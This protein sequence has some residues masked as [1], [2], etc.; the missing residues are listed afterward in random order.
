MLQLRTIINN[1][2]RYVD[3]FNDED[4]QL[5]YSFAEIQDIT[6]KNSSF[7]KSFSIP[8]S[9]NNNDIFQHYY[10]LNSSLTDYDIRTI[11][12]AS[13]LNDGY[14]IMK[15][16]IRLE[17]V[18]IDVKNVVYKVVFYSEVGRLTS[19]M[20]DKVL[21]QVD[22]TELD[23][24][25]D[26]EVITDSIYDPDFVDTDTYTQPYQD[27]RIT[28]MLA[29]Y[30]YDYDDSNNIITSSTPIIDYRDGLTSGY[31]D[32]IGTPLRFY[33]LKPAVQIKWLYEKIF[34]EAGFNIV[35]DFF[36]T[37]YF[38]R[39]Y[40]PLTFTDDSLYLRQAAKP[41][42]SWNI[43]SRSGGT[44]TTQSITWVN[45]NAG[46][47][48]LLER[49]IQT[50]TIT[51]NINA[52][53]Y[54]NF[55]FKPAQDGNYIIRISYGG[56][57]DELIPDTIDLS[58][59]AQF[60]FHQIELGGHNG[61]TGTTLF[62]SVPINIRPGSSFLDT[63]TFSVALS[64]NYDY[65]I[66][67]RTGEGIGTAQIN[68][69]NFEI[70]DGPRTIIGDV[71]LAL[72][73]PEAEQK[74][75]DFI[76]GIN[77]KFNLVVVPD[78]NNPETFVVE[79]VV[80]YIGKGDTLDWSRKLDYNSPINISPTTSVINGTLYY[81]AEKDEDYGNTEFTKSTNVLYGTR[82]VQLSTDYKSQ[83]T[84]FNDG[85]SNAVDDIVNN[86]SQPNITIPIYYITREENKEGDVV[87]FYNA[88]K[89][90]PRI[91]FR[92]MNLP[93]KNVGFN[94]SP[95]A[96]TLNTFY[97]EGTEVDMFPI[98]NRFTTYPFGVSGLTHAVNFN[99]THRFTNVEYDFRDTEDLYDVYYK[100]Y[101]DDLINSDNKILVA[102]FY[103]LPEEIASLKGS[104]RIFI[105]NNYYRINKINN[106]N[107]TNRDIVEV[108][109]LKLTGDYETHRK[110]CYT[111]TA[112]DDPADIIYVNTDLNWTLYAYVGKKVKLNNFCYD[113][114][115]AVC[116]DTKTYQ[117]I[118]LPFIEGS[119]QPETYNDC[120][121]YT[122]SDSVNI[123]NDFSGTTINPT[124][125]PTPTA[126][127][128]Q[129]YYYT[130]S[131][132]DEQILFLGRSTNFYSGGT[133]V[134][135]NA[136]S[137]VCWII[138][139]LVSI[140]NTNDITTTYINCDTCAADVPTPTPT[141]TKTPTPTPTFVCTCKT[142][143]INNDNSINL[144][145]D[146]KDCYGV[147][148]TRNVSPGQFFYICACN[149]TMS[150]TAD[151][152]VVGDCVPTTP[153]PTPTPTKTPTPT[154][155][156]TLAPAP[157]PESPTPTPSITAS[158]TPTNTLTPTPTLTPTNTPTNTI[159]PTPSITPTST[160]TPTP[161][162]TPTNTPT[163]TITPTLTPTNTPTNTPTKTLTPTPS[164]TPSITPSSTPPASGTTEANIYLSAVVNA[165]G[166]GI[167]PTISAATR[168][169]FTSLVSTGLYN[170]LFALYPMLG[171]NS[172]G[173]KF[174]G[175]N[176]VDTDNAYRIVFN[177]GWTFSSSGATPNGVNAYGNTYLTP[178]SATTDN[179]LHLS[180]YS[181]TNS[182]VV[183][184]TTMG[185]ES[186]SEYA[187]LILGRSGN[188]GYLLFGSPTN[189]FQPY[190]IPNST[191]YF[192]GEASGTTRN[193]YR[194]G[195]LLTPT[196]TGG[197][198]SVAKPLVSVYIGSNNSNGSAGEFDN[199]N[200]S[201]S[202]IGS[203]LTSVEVNT[204]STIINTFQ[205]SLGRNTY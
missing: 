60:F 125:T 74:Q 157:P 20:G 50:P 70:L 104:E 181:T 165:G 58:A 204:L 184:T 33:Y 53:T 61:L 182:F 34:S 23:H 188:L 115:E 179:N 187:R 85:F 189:G 82:Y 126:P 173:C 29:N 32:Y 107:L 92:G 79:P 68:F 41:Q 170:K 37:A 121:C 171:G 64:E 73:L 66:D 13:L 161:T 84:E 38:K 67:F 138:D 112:C 185:A 100:E 57:N 116:D 196:S 65:S 108:E 114:E 102:N 3:L 4:I 150:G 194:N 146:Y 27:G 25:Y 43:D 144:Y 122:L 90:L 80:D 17:S 186:P 197:L 28:Y 16:F 49:G 172:M 103:L 191:G 2:I 183:N 192:L 178:S 205:T 14:E 87:F 198:G 98:Y 47:S 35:S 96:T 169:L 78:V 128:Q 62:Q 44:I 91:M 159:T 15:G 164:I 54:S 156:K 155:T 24:P 18:S 168:T 105:N 6:S 83:Q 152:S 7:S 148:Q 22:F 203:A 160:L 130:M 31:F 19:N 59:E 123:Y 94:V 177:G 76:S 200:C 52:H 55:S 113:I 162:L 95:T 30:G 199:K 154:P 21:A 111:L 132:C 158:P 106:Y 89:T 97:L 124:P 176:P 5:D 127:Q 39:F 45:L 77:K 133:I 40:L 1:E 86:L 193:F 120:G 163:N 110:K 46:P 119:F 93:A 180:Y 136:S 149:G 26:I 42:L 101:I 190:S 174:N 118:T 137:N 175:L 75:I 201:F 141:P 145:I 10:D 71:N 147:N 166:T 36:D 143:Q 99:K 109:L 72:E 142:Y 153:T 167:T 88:R 48:G 129:Y 195:V 117:R 63:R 135:T 131:K 134:R 12:E 8:G 139:G 81:S 202:T 9:K 56:F 11:F 69:F 51:D 151:F 140:P